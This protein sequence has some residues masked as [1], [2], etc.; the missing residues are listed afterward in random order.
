[1]KS[2]LLSLALLGLGVVSLWS[3]TPEVLTPADLVRHPER[4]PESIVATRDYTFS[5]GAKVK[6][7]QVLRVQE[8]DAGKVV[9][10]APGDLF[11]DIPIQESGVLAAANSAWAKLT[12]AQRQIDVDFLVATPSLWP[13]RVRF[14]STLQFDGQKLSAGSEYPLLTC[15]RNE[16]NVFVESANTTLSVEWSA[17]DIVARARERALFAPEK[18]S[19]RVASALQGKLIDAKGQPFD[20][21]GFDEAQVFVLYY[22]ASWCGPCHKFSPSLV[23]FVNK[24]AAQNPQMAVIMMSNDKSDAELLGYMK[25]Q[26]MPWPAMPLSRLQKTPLLLSYTKGSIPQLLVLDRDGRVLS[27]SY[28]GNRYVGP[29]VALDELARLLKTGLAR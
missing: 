18:R 13:E 14:T 4:W 10:A 7:G 17:T 19:S 1:M 9:V 22:S 25:E 20:G 27:D 3:A 5:G 23:E 8:V 21:K 28:K 2:H 15:T 6:K 26:R 16:V 24:A 11:F 29:Q 12:P